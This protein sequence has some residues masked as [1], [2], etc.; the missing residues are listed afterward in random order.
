[1]PDHVSTLNEIFGRD[2][3]SQQ[4]AVLDGYGVHISVDRGHLVIHDGIGR[5]RRT[6]RYSKA[7]R[8]LRR[9]IVLG[10]AGS[11]TLEAIRWCA[12][13]GI[14]LYHLDLNGRVLAVAAP[15][16]HDDARLRRAQ[17]IAG[18]TQT[19]VTVARYLLGEKLR[20][21]Q[22]VARDLLE[23]RGAADEIAHY[24]EALDLADLATCRDLES[25]AANAYFAAWY[26]HVTITFARRDQAKIP[27]HWS[28]FIARS[29]PLLGGKT[30]RNAAD[31]INAMLNFAYS[32]VEAEARLACH[33]VGLDPGLG[34][35][36]TDNK[37]RASFTLDLIEA[38]RPAVDRHILTFVRSHIFRASDFHEA[39]DG[40][41][42]VLAP[43]THQLAANALTWH[44][45]LAPHAEAAARQFA[46]SSETLIRH[47][48]PLTKANVRAAQRRGD[49]PRPT[50]PPP[51]QPVPNRCR[52]CGAE[53]T[54]RSRKVCPACAPADLAR[55]GRE[56]LPRA[57]A[58]LAELRATGADPNADPQV[59]KRKRAALQRN[60]AALLAWQRDNPGVRPDPDMFLR[61]IQPRLTDRTT[62][63]L[64]AATGLSESACS[65]I[66]RGK[67]VPHF[68]HWAALRRLVEASSLDH[69]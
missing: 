63:E 25:R 64:Q 67:L 34:V 59:V 54:V 51:T 10:S 23:D 27:E 20:G 39:R 42:R 31:P 40:R 57:N 15:Q 68:R 45:A 17:A 24:A 49:N 12:D 2:S 60:R 46:S 53:L 38:V 11:V 29:T 48:T 28:A 41:C 9:V 7:E 52:D 26:P 5:T 16:T 66:R 56:Y 18:Y 21:Q 47:R 65:R 55:R 30:P 8:S 44:T 32:V 22:T 14:A 62:R 43:L 58:R 35:I 3:T 19:D 13:V 33:A 4:V 6:R 36:H 1:M 50:T 69:P 61:E 37:Q